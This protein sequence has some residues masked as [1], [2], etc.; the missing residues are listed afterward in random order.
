MYNS[1]ESMLQKYPEGH[2]RV[3]NLKFDDIQTFFDLED[4]G[5]S[6]KESYQWYESNADDYDQNVG[7]TFKSLGVGDEF[8]H[9]AKMWDKLRIRGGHRILEIGAGTGRDSAGIASRM[10]VSG[11]LHV[12]DV[13]REMLF[14]ARRKMAEVKSLPKIY[15][16]AVDAHKLPFQDQ[17]FDSVFHFGGLN[18]FSNP[19]LAL[20]E[21]VRVTKDG[22]RVVFGD[23]SIPG[24]L[25]N[26]EKMRAIHNSNPLFL[27][28]PPLESI[29]AE[30]RE[31]TLEYLFGDGFYSISFTV[32]REEP[33][34]DIDFAIPGLRGGTLRTRLTGSLEG[35]G[36][37]QKKRLYKHATKT[38]ASVHD[39]LV[40]LIDEH[41]P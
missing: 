10:G 27:F 31:L 1:I 13:Y 8:I 23:E 32:S 12:T 26:F 41:L 19:R 18:T 28:D 11:E 33:G 35:V 36:P 20:S 6:D 2:M 21:W 17:Y 34:G 16:S 40:N 22:G 37:D 7:L 5:P 39:I 15:F 3:E 38:G 24:W 29:P 4:L 9:R 25:R 14:D 30:A